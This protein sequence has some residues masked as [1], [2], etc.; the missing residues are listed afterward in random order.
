[1][2]EN[3]E[4][5]YTIA[6]TGIRGAVAQ[7]AIER[8]LPKHIGS[9]KMRTAPGLIEV[10]RLFTRCLG[11][12]VEQAWQAGL[13]ETVKTQGA[14]IAID[15]QPWDYAPGYPQDDTDL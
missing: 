1:M 5:I 15:V 9:S 2:K 6:I 8:E 11:D 7:G 14:S 4:V 10:P 13:M 3:D 12:E